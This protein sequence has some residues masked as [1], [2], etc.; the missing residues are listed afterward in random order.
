MFSAGKGFMSF[1]RRKPLFTKLTAIIIISEGESLGLLT[2]NSD[3]NINTLY[4]QT[5]N[6]SPS[7]SELHRCNFD[8]FHDVFDGF[9]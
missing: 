6:Y 8:Y 5:H 4:N 3:P 9:C 7:A 2:Q 1:E